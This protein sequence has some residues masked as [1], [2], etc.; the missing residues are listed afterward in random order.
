M[1]A[2]S[3]IF[4]LMSVV[5]LERL[6]PAMRLTALLCIAQFTFWYGLHLFGNDDVFIAAGP[7]ESWD[8]I[9]FGDSE[10]RTAIDRRLAFAPGQQLVFVRY[11]PRHTLR[12]WVYNEA[13][14]DGSRVVRALDLGP[15]ENTKLLRYYPKRTAWLIEPDVHPPRLTPYPSQGQ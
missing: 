9:N 13:D 12:E 14:I 3:C 7:Y 8:Y 15:E 5:G 4:L 10:G 1:A 11:S 2:L 6:G